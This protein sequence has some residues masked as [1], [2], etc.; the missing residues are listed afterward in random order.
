MQKIIN[1][2]KSECMPVMLFI[3]SGSGHF[4][5]IDKSDVCHL[6]MYH[7]VLFTSLTIL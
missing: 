7:C 5:N 2:M 4:N 6:S 1:N 3:K